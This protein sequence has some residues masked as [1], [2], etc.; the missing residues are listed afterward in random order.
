MLASESLRG[1]IKI[2][3]SLSKVSISRVKVEL[4]QE[5]ILTHKIPKP[6]L[7]DNHPYKA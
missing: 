3:N 7:L 5:F 4:I 6:S 2:D 1:F